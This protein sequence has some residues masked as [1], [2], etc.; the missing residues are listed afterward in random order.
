[1]FYLTRY[2]ERKRKR[3]RESYLVS[4]PHGVPLLLPLSCTSFISI[5]IFFII[6]NPF[7]VRKVISINIFVSVRGQNPLLRFLGGS[8]N[9]LS[10]SFLVLSFPTLP[11]QP[12]FLNLEKKNSFFPNR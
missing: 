11:L 1:M 9:S 6:V 12:C 10:I 5:N 7:K 2:R 3:K 8:L 4:H